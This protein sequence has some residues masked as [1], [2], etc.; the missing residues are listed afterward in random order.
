MIDYFKKITVLVFMA[1]LLVVTNARSQGVD[2]TIRYQT[3]E[4]WGVSLSWW[5]NL[6]G[7]YPQTEIVKICNDLTNPNEL[8]MNIFRYNIHGGDNPNPHAG[9]TADH[10]REDSGDITSYKP[11]SSSSYIWSANASQRKVLQEILRFRSD[12]ILDAISYSPPYW[13]TESGCSAG[14]VSAQPNLPED[15]EDEFA[16]FLTEIVKYYHD[17]LGITFRT[18]TGLNEP[19][20]GFWRAGGR[21]EGCG[22]LAQ[23]Q[24]TLIEEI[25][26]KLNEKSM[27]GYCR[28]AAPEESKINT[29]YA[30]LNTFINNELMSKMDQ[31][32]THSYNSV[33]HFRQ[34]ISRIA[35]TYEKTLWQSET[36]PLGVGLP[37]ALENNLYVAAEQ[38]IPDLKE[39]NAHAW[40]EWQPASTSQNWG[41]YTLTVPGTTLTKHKNYYFR[42]QF[43]KYLKA[44]YTIIDIADERSVAAISPDDDELVI[45]M[46]NRSKSN[47]SLNYDLSK[48]ET[49]SA[50]SQ[51]IRTSATED[52][53][54]L[55]PLSISNN[56]LSYSA[57]AESITTF[58]IGVSTEGLPNQLVDGVYEIKAKHSG[59]YMSV[60]GASSANVANIEQYEYVDADNLKFNISKFGPDYLI[61]PIYND[62]VFSIEGTSISNGA[63]LKQYQE[64]GDDSQ[65][66]VI[67]PDDSGYYK[68][69]NRKSNLYLAVA[70]E[71][72]ENQADIIQWEDL[73]TDNYL[74]AF[75]FNELP[76]A[77]LKDPSPRTLYPN[78]TSSSI[79][80]SGRG[81]EKIE[82]DILTLGG[83]TIHR[84]HA[85]MNENIDISSVP[86]GV[87]LLRVKTLN[88]IEIMKL[89]I[90]N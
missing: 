82:V 72:D 83:K 44:G 67:V 14:G 50:T 73:G 40:V 61:S 85:K 31:I 87:Y 39:L 49:V 30:S 59:K 4:G 75:E 63:S 18:I 5:A 54:E 53:K 28:P 81:Y 15:M 62:L 77:I 64:Y 19:S 51:V 23:Q 74:W 86:T 11:S 68:I 16:D 1:M 66:F 46:V 58:L 24:V 38:I 80:I 12:A 8:N 22:I 6:V 78:P 47:A 26:N 13:M 21:Q 84:I 10:F 27:L 45:V 55:S 48:F 70:D 88:N 52:T 71:S 29:S 42:K 79:I 36:G 20:S 2:P 17:N 90:E 41:Y 33:D 56:A 37:N 32:N 43:S 57:P 76:L 35:H 89:I 34:G 3:L 25:Y 9:T 65:R 69:Y 7:Q 60:N